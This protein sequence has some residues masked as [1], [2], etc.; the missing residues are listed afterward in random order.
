M[1]CPNCGN[2][3]IS[4]W[5]YSLIGWKYFSCAH[6]SSKLVMKRFGMT[7]WR[8]MLFAAVLIT[9]EILFTNDITVLV[10]ASLS[11]T[12]LIAS[13]V[14]AVFAGLYVSW[15]D[16]HV[17]LDPKHA[18]V[19]ETQRTLSASAEQ[20]FNAFRD[21]ALLAQWWGPKG[22]TNTFDRFEFTP[23]GRWSFVMH[24]PDGKDYPNESRFGRIVPN[25]VVEI[26]HLSGHHFVLTLELRETGAGT[27][28]SWQ[29]TFDTAE[30][31][32]RLAS[33]V[34]VANEQNLERLAAEVH[35]AR[36]AA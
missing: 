19:F 2:Q 6:C 17:E 4:F 27:R 7:F 8:V 3:P 31:Y 28:V 9:V 13:I 18:R 36:N 29:Q 25:R 16:G 30:H 20:L 15:R 32:G 34:A 21:P 26:E 10:G 33:F 5:S 11:T 24:G 23:G 35:R 22:F 12:I 1:H 14:L